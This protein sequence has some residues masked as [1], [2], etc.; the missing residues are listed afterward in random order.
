MELPEVDPYADMDDLEI[1]DEELV[2]AKNI[3]NVQSCFEYPRPVYF[4]KFVG[5][6]EH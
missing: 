4:G 5:E 3:A 1:P 6:F 2:A